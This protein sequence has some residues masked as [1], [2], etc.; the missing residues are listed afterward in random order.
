MAVA[1]RSVGPEP[2]S[3]ATPIE[4]VLVGA[5]LALVEGVHDIVNADAHA[6]VV[7]GVEVTAADIV[8]FTAIAMAVTVAALLYA[9][10]VRYA[11]P[12]RAY[13]VLG[14]LSVVTF[15]VGGLFAIPIVLLGAAIGHWEACRRP[16]A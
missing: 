12:R 4:V 6:G 2:E 8:L 7:G 5:V 9:Y 13:L 1:E 14:G 15:A 10:R 11:P 16:V 3:I